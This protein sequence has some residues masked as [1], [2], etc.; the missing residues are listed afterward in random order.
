M[1]QRLTERPIL[2]SGEMIRAILDERKNQTRRVV[3][4]QP[5]RDVLNGAPGFWKEPSYY[6]HVWK[7]PYGRP[8]SVLWVRETWLPRAEGKAFLYRAD[9]DPVNAAGT[10]AM[11]GGWKPSIHMLRRASRITLEITGVRVQRLQDIKADDAIAEGW[12]RG[13]ELYPNINTASK[14]LDWY[15]K[16]WDSINAKRGFGWHVNPFVWAITF[17]RV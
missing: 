17:K 6:T 8:G 16:L 15:R 7:C 2:F 11:Y 3:K 10:G 12:P 13:Q 1:T 4:P 14:A 5:S 9:F